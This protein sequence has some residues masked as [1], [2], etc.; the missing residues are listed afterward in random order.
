MPGSFAGAAGGF[1][2]AVGAREVRG[3]AV[4]G[5]WKLVFR[6]CSVVCS[7]FVGRQPLA[8]GGFSREYVAE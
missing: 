7:V 1:H 4:N 6:L 2:W 8:C 5:S 3:A